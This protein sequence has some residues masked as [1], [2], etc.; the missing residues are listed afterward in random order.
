MICAFYHA[1]HENK[2]AFET[3]NKYKKNKHELLQLCLSLKIN[4]Q[5]SIDSVNK[6]LKNEYFKVNEF[7]QYNK[8]PFGAF[9]AESSSS[10]KVYS[11]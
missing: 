4:L 5:I 1:L 11:T 10:Q 3:L 7:L 2:T 9:K 6:E 8:E